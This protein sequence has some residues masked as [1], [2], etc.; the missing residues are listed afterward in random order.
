MKLFTYLRFLVLAV[1]GCKIYSIF[2]DEGDLGMK[3][4]EAVE[5]CVE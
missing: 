1:V 4:V 3:A 2:L 5:S